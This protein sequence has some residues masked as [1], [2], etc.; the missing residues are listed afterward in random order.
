LSV[1]C[2]IIYAS[3]ILVASQKQNKFYFWEKR[4]LWLNN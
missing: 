4:N 1:T 2:L 3:V